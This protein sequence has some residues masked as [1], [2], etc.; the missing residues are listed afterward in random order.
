MPVRSTRGIWLLAM[1]GL[2]GGSA[3]WSLLRGA[4]APQGAEPPAAPAVSTIAKAEVIQAELKSNME[5]LAKLIQGADYGEDQQTEVGSLAT[6]C[7]VQAQA[8]GLHDQENSVKPGAMAVMKAA[9]G[10]AKAAKDQTAA[11][12]ELSKLE[13]ALQA[14][15]GGG[16]AQWEKVPGLGRLMHHLVG[17]ETKIDRAID[18]KRFKSRGKNAVGPAATVALIAQ[19]IHYDTHEVHEPAQVG[20]WYAFSEQMRSAAVEVQLAA[21]GDSAD[22]AKAAAA[23][24][25]QSCEACHA[26]F[27][28][29]G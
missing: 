8:L 14:P 25:T 24:L 15:A 4:D 21:Q 2:C 16:I 20:E 1:V 23:K 28:K 13:A 26:V 11:K 12:E 27:H 17:L 7:A 22:A 3:A 9:Q 10:L 6:V 29:E 18:P 19:V 5:E